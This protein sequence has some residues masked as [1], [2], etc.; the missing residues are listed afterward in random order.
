MNP[1]TKAVDELKFRIPRDI[2]KQVFQE[3][4]YN[5]RNTPIGIDEQLLSRVIRPRVLVDCNL[6]GGTEALVPLDSTEREVVDSFI[7]IYRIPKDLTQHRSIMSVLSVS[8]MSAAIGAGVAGMSNYKSC[9]VTPALVLGQAMMD[10]FGPI[11]Q[12]S[13][14]KAQLIGE[15]IVMVRD[16]IPPVGY[17]YLRCIL[18]N[19]ENMSHI[20]MR[21]IPAFC[22]LCVLAV[23]SFIYNEYI[24]TMDKGYLQGGQEIG[25][26]KQI[27]EGYADAEGMYREYLREK[28]TAIAFMNDTETFTRF[29]KLNIGG[30]R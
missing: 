18:S 16:T 29:L 3:K 6:V 1:I 15:N 8:Y 13:T 17:G 27:I 20:Q 21:S 4:S 5:W 9:S 22:E 2:L 30:N 23:K 28:W 7:T 25:V 26:F 19:D 24:I 14:A 11:P 10:A 12:T